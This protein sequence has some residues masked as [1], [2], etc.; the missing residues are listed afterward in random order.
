MS[1]NGFKIG[2]KHGRISGRIPLSQ[3]D[4]STATVLAVDVPDGDISLR[5]AARRES[6]GTGQGAATSTSGARVK[7]KRVVVG[8]AV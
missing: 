8:A 5:E 7:K 4:A 1:A 6:G 3:L 2:T